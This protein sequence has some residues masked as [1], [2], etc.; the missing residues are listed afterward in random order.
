ME[1][2]DLIQIDRVDLPPPFGILVYIYGDT[3][4]PFVLY[5]DIPADQLVSFMRIHDGQTVQYPGTAYRDDYE[6]WARKRI[7]G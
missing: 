1:V 4:V 5:T 7:I 6:R 2:M 3:Y